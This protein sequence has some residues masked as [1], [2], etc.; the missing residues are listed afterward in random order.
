MTTVTASVDT[1]GAEVS[2]G[3]LYYAIEKIK[4]GAINDPV[5]DA[6]FTYLEAAFLAHVREEA[7]GKRRLTHVFDYGVDGGLGNPLWKLVKSGT[8]ANIVVGYT[9]IESDNPVPIPEELQGKITS[10][11]I[12]REKAQILESAA[13]VII[14]RKNAK[15]LVYIN[16]RAGAGFVDNTPGFTKGNTTFHKGASYIER[17]GGGKFQNQFDN[18]FFTWWSLSAGKEATLDFLANKLTRQVAVQSARFAS[19]KRRVA[20]YRGKA[21]KP[22]ATPEAKAKAEAMIQEITKQWKGTRRAQL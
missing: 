16:H 2:I 14:A 1:Y 7:S 6:A 13:P 19:A 3:T 20:I 11:H 21:A 10:Q 8:K 17:A 4:K 9:F 12:F 5:L 15:W 18:E 22:D